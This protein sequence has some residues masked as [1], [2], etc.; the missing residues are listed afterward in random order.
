MVFFRDLPKIK[1][2]SPCRTSVGALSHN[3]TR[4]LFGGFLLQFF[5]PPG[6]P[7]KLRAAAFIRFLCPSAL[8]GLGLG[9]QIYLSP[10]PCVQ[11]WYLTEHC[12]RQNLFSDRIATEEHE[13][14][15]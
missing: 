1:F 4:R 11:R 15:A 7:R 14:G 8:P 6:V 9:V 10:S 13:E 5:S 2:L 12:M 3:E